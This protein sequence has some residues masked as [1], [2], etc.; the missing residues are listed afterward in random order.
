MNVAL[1]GRT[2]CVSFA[3]T[4]HILS[5]LNL[6]APPFEREHLFAR[7]VQWTCFTVLIGFV[8]NKCT[9]LRT[10]KLSFH[11]YTERTLSDVRVNPIVFAMIRD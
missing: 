4:F 10:Y 5:R 6:K 9:I 8:Q 3:A 1:K 2:N 11:G 7:S